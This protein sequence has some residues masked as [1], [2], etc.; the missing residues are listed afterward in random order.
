MVEMLL[1]L[2]V[3]LG[4]VFTI[5]EIGYVSFQL[6]V[7]NHATYEVA[8]VGG[9]TWLAPNGGAGRLSALMKTI[10]PLATV[11]CTEDKTLMD[12][13]AQLQNM[14]LVCTG[15]ENVKL[16]FPISSIMLAKPAGSGTRAL[17]ATVRMPIEQP[18]AQ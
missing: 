5:M 13:Q 6:I 3:F 12:P 18:L 10:L 11:S 14:D 15:S 2:P 9:M 4:I 1:I 17:S 16:V 7:L 8:R